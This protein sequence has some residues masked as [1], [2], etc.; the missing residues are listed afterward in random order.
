MARYNSPDKMIPR[1]GL[2]GSLPT[3]L[4]DWL[5]F[6][7]GI[8]PMYILGSSTKNMF[9]SYKINK[10]GAILR[11]YFC[12]ASLGRGFTIWILLLGLMELD[13]PISMLS[14]NL[15]T[16]LVNLPFFSGNTNVYGGFFDKNT[17]PSI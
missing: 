9:L 13:L 2:D 1:Q 5:F 14:L 7:W 12:L 6:S 3:P 10:I 11:S 15:T 4:V 17:F 8:H 16:P